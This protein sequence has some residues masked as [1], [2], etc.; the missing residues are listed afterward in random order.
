MAAAGGDSTPNPFSFTNGTNAEPSQY[1]TSNTINITGIS[2]AVLVSSSPNLEFSINGSAFTTNQSVILNDQTLRV[3]LITGSSFSTQYTGSIT[4]GDTTSTWNVTTR[5]ADTTPNAFSF[6]SVNGVELSTVTTSSVVTVSGLE[7]NYPVTVSTSG[8]GTLRAGTSTVSGTFVTSLTVTTSATGTLVLEAR[9]TS[10]SSFN[11]STSINVTVGNGSATSFTVTT[12]VADLTPVAFSFSNSTGV[13][14]ETV[15]TSNTITISGLEPNYTFSVTASGS[16]GAGVDAGTTNLTGTFATS[17]VVTTSATGTIVVAARVTSVYTLNGS[18]TCTVTVGTQSAVYTVT[19]RSPDLVPD[20]Y[21]IP[22]STGVERSTVTTSGTVTISGLEPA[23]VITVSASGGTVDAGTN[24]LSGSFATG[25]TLSTT[26]GG[27]ILIAARGTS[28]ANFN[29]SSTVTITVASGTGVTYTITTR[30][31]DLVPTTYSIPGASGL[32]RNTVTTSST[33]TVS[34]LEPNHSITVSASG[35]TVDAG[36]TALSGTFAS[37]KTVTTSGTGTIVLAARGTTSSSF[38]TTVTVSVTVASGSPVAYNISTRVADT[39][40]ANFSFT[41][42]TDATVSTVYTT[43]TVTITGLEPSTSFTITASGGTVD[44]GTSTLSGTFASSKTVNTSATGTLVLRARVTSSASL[45]T[46]VNCSVTVGTVSDTFTVTTRAADL[47]P[48]TFAFTD[49]TAVQRSTVYTSETITVTGLEPNYTFTI[50]T[51]GTIGRSVDAGTTTLSGNFGFSKTV[52]TS[53]TGTIVVAARVTSSASYGTAANCVVDIGTVSDTFTITTIVLD[54]QPDP[55]SFT[56]VTNAELSTVYTSNTVTITGLGANNPITV[57]SSNGTVDA[58]TSALSGTF[59]SSKSVTA[60]AS[61]TLVI[62][63]RGTSSANLSTAVAISVTVGSSNAG[64]SIT[65]RA[66]DLVPDQFTFT[67]VTNAAL[68]TQYT[69]NTV[70]VTGLEPNTSITF[71]VGN[72]AT[73]YDAGPTA[74]SGTWKQGGTSSATVTTSALG[75]FL[76]ASRVTSN[77]L[78]SGSTGS[79]ITIGGVSDTFTVTTRAADTTPNAFSFASPTNESPNTT[80]TS[81]TITV[82]GLDANY[83]V[84]VSV[85]GGLID[86]GTSTLSGTFQNSKVITTS[87]TGTLVVAARVT[88]GAFGSTTTATVTVGTGSANFSATVRTPDTSLESGLLINGSIVLVNVTPGTGTYTSSSTLCGTVE[89]STAVTIIGTNGTIG[90][91]LSSTS[92]LPSSF[93]SGSATVTTNASGQFYMQYNTSN[94]PT[95]RWGY[96]LLSFSVEIG[97]WGSNNTVLLSSNSTVVSRS[98]TQ[99]RTVPANTYIPAAYPSMNIGT[100]NGQQLTVSFSG[101]APNKE[102]SLDGTTWNT[103]NGTFTPTAGSTVIIY[104]RCRAPATVGQSAECACSV[105][106][107]YPGGGATG[108]VLSFFVTAS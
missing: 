72:S 98:N 73:Q 61:G 47:T 41:D 60:S 80:V 66:A 93:S 9:Q 103:T 75:R 53:A 6:T 36:T 18:A 102:W 65:T 71:S 68:S 31:P 19:T 105:N 43:S 23:T 99:N 22:S 33:V 48:A 106:L 97:S 76:L 21:N 44:A 35:G 13:E 11:T 94:V 10:S 55:F 108:A 107:E 67:D 83:P 16:T 26:A 50:T 51:S 69:S 42:V 37:S 25:K 14:R 8:G 54:T 89:P 91:K 5:A 74:L 34:G 45:G 88:T 1:F 20:T 4:V 64:W 2:G 39:T 56:A 85:S 12:R 82:S 100:V 95:Y 59:A 15:T 70:T 101:S 78:P 49:L 58:G 79:T 29:T 30:G 90:L 46:A 92:T 17:K 7:P 38:N 57:S 52:T 27:T 62:A 3:R 87:A 81:S 84:G 32:E 28:S 96:H 40:P 77:A 86:A 63:A 24:S 104:T